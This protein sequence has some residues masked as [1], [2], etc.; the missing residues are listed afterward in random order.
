MLAHVAFVLQITLP[1]YI[2]APTTAVPPPATAVPLP[3]TAVPPATADVPPPATAVP[4]AII[5]AQQTAEQL[6]AAADHH[7]SPCLYP[8][9][10]PHAMN[11]DEASPT[12]HAPPPSHKHLT[13]SGE[14]PGA[15]PESV[16]AITVGQ[17]RRS[18]EAGP[19]QRPAS[20]YLRHVQHH[21]QVSG[22]DHEQHASSSHGNKAMR[23]ALDSELALGVGSTSLS[24]TIED[25]S[26]PDRCQTVDAQD[27]DFP[28]L[29]EMDQHAHQDC[30]Q[31][32]A[33]T[34]MP[35]EHAKAYKHGLQGTTA[36]ADHEITVTHADNMDAGT[37]RSSSQ[38][39]QAAQHSSVAAAQETLLDGRSQQNLV[40]PLGLCNTQH[41]RL[42]QGLHKWSDLLLL[43]PPGVL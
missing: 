38:G 34:H 17:S 8:G 35:D 29:Q 36:V 7:S 16:C 39:L 22:A 1:S 6:P 25:R 33:A 21:I 37:D 13:E 41:H 31:D 26:S 11:E 28:D 15:R 3:A 2:Q 27:T 20:T 42:L 43:R 9:S 23:S 32:C 24:K 14:V 4:P 18:M 30:H 10:Q 12:Q 40:S 19:D 5:S